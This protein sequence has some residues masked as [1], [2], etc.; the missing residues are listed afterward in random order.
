MAVSQSLQLRDGMSAVLQRI[1][2]RMD[3]VNQRFERMQTLAAQAAPTDLYSGLQADL[4]AVQQEVQRTAYDFEA[5]RESMQN[6]QPP[7]NNL[8][9]TLKRLGT[10]F[11]GSKIVTGLV[12]MSDTLTQTTARLNLMNDG[13][14]STADLQEMIYQSALRSR[15]A[16]ADTAAAVSKMGVLAPDAFANNEETIAFVEQLNKQFKIAGT[17]QEGQAAA[18]L[19]LTQ[20]MGAGVLRGEELNSVFEQAPTIIQAINDYLGITTGELRDLAADGQIT[21]EIVKNAMFAAAD[22][23]NARFESI[24]MTWADVWTQA[25]S[26]AT[27]ALQPLLNAIN[28]VANNL[29]VI[30]PLVIGVGIA[31]G[32]FQLAAHWTQIASAAAAIYHGVVTF[33]SIGF[34]VLTGNAA[35]ASAAVFTFNSALLASPIT[36]VI[37]L[38]AVLVGLLFAIVAAYNKVTGAHVKALGLITGFLASACAF[39]FNTVIGLINAIIQYIWTSFVEPFIGI[40]EWVLNVC[41]G[42][43]D[44]FGDAVA[45][46]IGNII[47]WFLSLGK[48]VT[49]IIDAIFGTNWTGGLESL[50]DTVLQWGKNENAIT[51]SRDA[52]TIDA[53]ITYSSAWD[54]GYNWGANLQDSIADKLNFGVDTSGMDTPTAVDPTALL[55]DI[56]DNTDQIADD[57]ELS[58]EDLE[59]LRDIAERQ[60]I[61]RFTTA[62]IHVEMINN[63]TISSEMDIDGV[64][65]L[66]EA[67]VQEQMAVAAEG[68]HI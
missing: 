27:M 49:K 56:A 19:Q 40:V 62:E 14:Q 44:S 53:R 43:F 68:V 30:A 31:F 12:G 1:S 55:S 45:N 5:L 13:L 33:L 38:L 4:A 64:V 6:A 54:A 15:G 46:L 23:T 48:I 36:W 24:P 34:G 65:N 3:A 29:A 7:A 18:M 11:V 58:S 41:N 22:E 25:T 39:I 60:E 28:W 16:Y 20:A 21:A 59:L 2:A 32:V 66:L 52:P 51:L 8:M 35:A 50:Q 42:G 10:A 47:S 63:N 9:T 17:S 67:K 61:N 57:V 26:M 37:I